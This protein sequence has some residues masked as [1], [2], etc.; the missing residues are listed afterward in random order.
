MLI[1]ELSNLRFIPIASSAPSST[2]LAQPSDFP[3]PG[4]FQITFPTRNDIAKTPLQCA[5]NQLQGRVP[6]GVSG[7]SW[8]PLVIAPYPYDASLIYGVNGSSVIPFEHYDVDTG[9]KQ[10]GVY[11]GGYQNSTTWGL[12]YEPKANIDGNPFFYARFL[13]PG[14]QD[15][16][17][18]DAL[19]DGEF[20]AFI[21]VAA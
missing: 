7:Y 10:D 3:N 21:K 2:L 1:P 6:T 11:L 8:Q 14:S 17:S 18:G 20:T 16:S 13:G 19:F 9:V 4:L 12:R 15:P 5:S